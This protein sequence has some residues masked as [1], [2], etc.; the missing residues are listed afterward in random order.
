MHE[1]K[2]QL[3]I[4]TALLIVVIAL[5]GGLFFYL[6]T[7]RAN[8]VLPPVEEDPPITHAKVRDAEISLDPS[9]VFTQTFGGSGEETIVD[10]FYNDNLLYIFGNTTS[11]DFD[12]DAPGAF[13]AILNG[14]GKT[15]D[16]LTYGGTLKAVTLYNGGYLMAIDRD[17]TPVAL[18]VDYG[19]DVI[20]STTL[21]TV[22]DEETLDIKYVDGGYLFITSLVQNITGF[23]RL[24]M[25]MLDY[26]LEFTGSVVTDEV[27]SLSYID[28]LDVMGE[29]RLVANAMSDLRNMLCIGTWGKKLA[30]YPLEFSYKVTG[31]WIIGDFYYLATSDS[32][33]MLIKTD[34]TVIELC[35]TSSQTAIVGDQKCM[36]IIANNTFFCVSNDKVLFSA[37][38]GPTSFY[39]DNYI[40][41]VS[42]SGSRTTVRSFLNG[43]KAFESTFSYEITS[44]K[45]ITCE[46]GMFVIG[47]TQGTFGGNDISLIKVSY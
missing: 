3:R 15:L 46:S 43:S 36:Y 2:S 14:S 17:M 20:K 26:S 4:I 41:A 44:P 39:V 22:R 28:T 31:F 18:A 11:N 21:S 33:T 19:G 34:N 40:Y 10:V 12:F 29:Y 8:T 37:E 47:N 35:G 38:Y 45:I 27:Y 32:A 7:T 42:T 30:H 23:T 6:P 13:L 9:L 16:F 25:T 24:K 1:S 5:A